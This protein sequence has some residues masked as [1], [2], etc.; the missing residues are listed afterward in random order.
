MWEVYTDPGSWPAWT[1]DITHGCWT[2]GTDCRKG[3]RGEVKFKGLPKGAFEIQAADPPRTFTTVTR[4]PIG[5]RIRFDHRLAATAHGTR[6][7]ERISFHGLLAPLVGLIERRRIRRNWPLAR[8]G[9]LGL[10]AAYLLRPAVV[11]IG[12]SA[13]R[14]QASRRRARA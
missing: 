9:K 3:S 4:F 11:V 12:A 7:E 13:Q 6:I 5:L 10:A 2:V 8:R 1:P 14:R